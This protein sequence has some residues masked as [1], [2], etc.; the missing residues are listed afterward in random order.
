MS[1]KKLLITI[2]L[3][4][5]FGLIFAGCGTGSTVASV[6]L[7]DYSADAPI[8]IALGE[9]S[10]A[11][12]TLVVTHSGGR[13]EELALTEEMIPETEKL[14]FFQEG[15]HEVTL[16][17]EG[18]STV[19]LVKVSRMAFPDG[20]VLKD[21][22]RTYTGEKFTVEVEGNVP[23]GTRV[24]Y[25]QGNT[26]VNAGSYDVT[27]ILQCEGYTTKMLSARVVVEKAEYDIA[28]ALMYDLS[29]VYDTNA[30]S[31]S[32]KGKPTED[33]AGNVSYAPYQLPEGV[34]VSYTVTKTKEG[35]GTP[36]AQ[37]QA[38]DGNEA[39]DAGTYEVRARYKG[40]EANYKQIPDSVA[41]L[42]IERATYD[43]SDADF[44]DITYEYTGW[45]YSLRLP[46]GYDMPPSVNVS[47]EI[48]MV[49]NALGE[50]VE[51]QFVPGNTAVNAGVYAVKA[52][53]E[54]IG[55]HAT[56]YMTYPSE[57]SAYLIIEPA[58]YGEQ[59]EE[60][61][62]DYMHFTFEEGAE[63][64]LIL[65]GSLPIDVFP[66]FTVTDE[67]G[68]AVVGNVDVDIIEKVD[69]EGAIIYDINYVYC[70]KTRVEGRFLCEV[71][72]D[73]ADT[74][75]KKI[76][77]MYAEVF[78]E[79]PV[80]AVTVGDGTDEAIKTTVAGLDY[81]TVKL[82]VVEG[83]EPHE[84]ALTEAMIF[85]EEEKAKLTQVGVHTVKCVYKG[86]VFEIKVEVAE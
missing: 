54:V 51:E 73:H 9:F 63:Y 75:Y 5:C 15:Q 28:D 2:A 79:S 66:I 74:N 50:N 43:L 26:F 10:Y 47:Y 42:E 58:S 85:S 60:V 21:V 31:I 70:I 65:D 18:A 22:T 83:G 12:R 14:K 52:C 59:M 23:N 49:K 13:T 38:I 1:I 53:F 20:V 37:V 61:Y 67:A 77:N 64:R 57:K 44:A 41:V 76:D 56:N 80:T 78:I 39:I 27:A 33:G 82:T 55:R 6:S 46:L 29:T 81:S 8:E 86:H 68:N 17:Y 84:M 19:I 62:L 7:K 72:F 3:L 4:C 45:E 69:D 36:V 25:P 34:T 32:V 35:D 48:A 71:E 40:D 24:L 16:T 11:G 30:H